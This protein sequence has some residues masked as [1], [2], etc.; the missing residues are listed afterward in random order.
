MVRTTKAEA[1]ITWDVLIQTAGFLIGSLIFTCQE[2][3]IDHVISVLV[4]T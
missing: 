1:V 3:A 2:V 4:S